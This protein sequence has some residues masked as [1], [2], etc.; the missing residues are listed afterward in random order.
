MSP[1]SYRT[2]PPRVVRQG[3]GTASGDSKSVLFGMIAWCGS[4]PSTSSAVVRR[5]TGSWIRRGSSTRSRAWTPTSSA[6]RRSTRAN[7]A[8]VRLAYLACGGG[9][10]CNGAQVRA[11]LRGTPGRTWTRAEDTDPP[12]APA[13][14]IALLSRYP[15]LAWREVRLAGSAGAGA[16][17]AARAE[18][19]VGAGR[20]TGGRARPG[21]L[22]ARTGVGRQHA[23]VVPPGLEPR[24]A[25]A[26]AAVG[27]ATARADRADG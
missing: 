27:P 22:T 14:G 21:R 15:V 6:S 10:R 18:A 17:P 19:R 16:V 9:D 2:A 13:Y 23:P 3:Y 24:A 20:A 4:R 5:R 7:L 12:D 25:A 26:A 11:G 1:A 8:P